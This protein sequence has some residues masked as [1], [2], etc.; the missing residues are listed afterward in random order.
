MKLSSGQ[1]TVSEL[2]YG[3][4]NAGKLVGGSWNMSVI[5]V[6]LVF[7]KLMVHA[8]KKTAKMEVSWDDHQRKNTCL[9]FD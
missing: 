2:D 1:L 9:Y 8:K 3:H 4:E 6:G 5:R 7:W